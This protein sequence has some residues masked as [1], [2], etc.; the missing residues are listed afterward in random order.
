[1]TALP[2]SA[3]GGERIAKVLARAGV[4]SRREVERMIEAGRITLDG[5]VLLTPAVLV[6]DVAR[7]RVDGKPVAAAQTSRM[8]RLH[9]I[10]GLVTTHSDPQGRPTVFDRLPADIPRVISVGRL[11]QMTEGLLLLT[12]DGELARRLELPANGWRRRY[13]VRVAGAVEPP[14]LAALA[15]G[16]SIEGVNYGPVEARI[17]EAGPGGTWL[18]IVISEGKNREVRNILRHLG[19]SVLQLVRVAFGPFVLGD[20]RPGALAE[21]P[22]AEVAGLAAGAAPGRSR[23]R[24][25]G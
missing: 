22:P 1:M 3:G 12:N 9:K 23:G 11:D 17:E 7:V 24:P 16:V 5:E 15:R 13:R 19:L 4:A 25:P 6:D 14:R 18:L 10:V 21:V 2:R 20:L 8:W